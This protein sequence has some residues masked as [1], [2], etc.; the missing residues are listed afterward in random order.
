MAKSQPVAEAT[1][2]ADAAPKADK[3]ASVP[4]PTRTAN[5]LKADIE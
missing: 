5:L 2:P 1:P 4:A 3:L